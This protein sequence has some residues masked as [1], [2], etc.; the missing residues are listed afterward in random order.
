MELG[1]FSRARGRDA[2]V[3]FLIIFVMLENPNVLHTPSAIHI[4]VLFTVIQAH[5][6]SFLSFIGFYCIKIINATVN[7]AMGSLQIHFPLSFLSVTWVEGSFSLS[8]RCQN[9][10]EAT[11]RR[12][13]ARNG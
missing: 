1:F 10:H 6:A 11:I 5:I 9:R 13:S 4:R 7:D 3:R 12:K 8:K 2:R